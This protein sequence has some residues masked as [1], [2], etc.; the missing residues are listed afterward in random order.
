MQAENR[1]RNSRSVVYRK[2]LDS[3]KRRVRGMWIRGKQYYANLTVTDAFCLF[4]YELKP[5]FMAL[6]PAAR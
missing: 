3:R 1:P 5:F 2:V 4:P 6:S